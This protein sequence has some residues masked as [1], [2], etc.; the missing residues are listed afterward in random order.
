ML[1]P[2]YSAIFV[3]IHKTAGQSMERVFL[4]SLH[5]TSVL[6]GSQYLLRP[7]NDPT[8]GHERLAH[9]TAEEYVKYK[10][11]SKKEFESFYKFSLVRN[12]WARVFSFYKFRGFNGLIPFNRFVNEYLPLYFEKEHWFFRLQA[13]FIYNA[14]NELV[15]NYVGKFEN[16]DQDFKKIA[17]ALTLE[18]TKL[19]RENSSKKNT[20]LTKKSFNL[21][22]KHPEII[23]KLRILK[24][25]EDYTKNLYTKKQKR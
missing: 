7:N 2:E 14:K 23:T 20:L 12:P 10:Y 13:D 18:F 8:K 9:L 22:K 16:L 25:T 11:V 5:K 1:L 3:H 24:P 19:P 4:D 6:D 17:S 15:V 21:W